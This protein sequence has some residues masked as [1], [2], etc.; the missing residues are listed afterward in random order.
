MRDDE[1]NMKIKSNQLDSLITTN[2][3][4]IIKTNKNVRKYELYSCN[5]YLR[6]YWSI[7]QK[8][9]NYVDKVKTC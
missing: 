8:I 6:K 7:M 1:G 2:P 9:Y 5:V 3:I 4:N